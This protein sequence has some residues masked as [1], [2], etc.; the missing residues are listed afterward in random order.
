MEQEKIWDYLQNGGLHEGA[1]LD[2]RGRYMVKK[3][4]PGKRVLNIGSG[5]ATLNG[6]QY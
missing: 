5:L 2:C 3:L 4:H 6:M 1:F